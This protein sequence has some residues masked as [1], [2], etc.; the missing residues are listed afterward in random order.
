MVSSPWQK[1]VQEAQLPFETAQRLCGLEIKRILVSQTDNVWE[2]YFTNCFSVSPSDQSIVEELLHS[3]FGQE[4]KLRLFFEEREEGPKL[5]ELLQGIEQ[6]DVDL[7]SIEQEDELYNERFQ[8][9]LKKSE[10]SCP[11]ETGPK[12]V[13]GRKIT[14]KPRSLVEIADESPN[15][16]IHGCVT[17]IRDT[18]RL[19]TGTMLFDFDITDYTNSIKVKLFI[20]VE[21]NRKFDIN[22]LC[23][24]NWYLIK[25]NVKFDQYSQELTMFPTD[26]MTSKA[27]KRTDQAAEKR[28]ELHLHTKLSAMDAMNTPA[29]LIKQAIAWGH[30]AIAIT[31]HGVVQAFPDA[32]K[33]AKV[34]KDGTPPPIKIIYGLEGYLIDGDGSL[35]MEQMRSKRGRS[36]AAAT[37]EEGVADDL[38]KEER[39]GSW[40][41]IL[42]AKNMTGIRNLYKLVSLSHLDFF[43][44]KPR[45]PRQYIEKYREGLI[46]GSACEA[47]ELYQQILN[48]AGPDVIGKTVEFYDYLEIQPIMNNGFMI[49][50]GTVADEEALRK[51]NRTILQLGRQYGK[52]VVATGDV[53][54]LNPEDEVYRRI[55][56]AGQHYR[57]ADIQPPLYFRTTEE[58]LQEFSYLGQEDAYEVVVKAPRAIASQVEYLNPIPNQLQ[59]PKIEGAEEQIKTMAE[60]KAL[61]LYG[62][63]LPEPVAKRLEKELYSI[64][65][66]GYAVLY[67]IAHKLVKHSNEDG[68]VVGSRGS[69]GSS[70]VAFL[71]DITEVNPLEPHYLCSH[72]HYI[73][74]GDQSVFG[75]GADMP[76]KT[77]PVC[78]QELYKD[79]F[80]IPF[81][82][83]LGFDGDKVPDIDLNFSGEYQ[84]QAQK[85]TEELFGA[86]NVF[87]AG[88]IS[89]VAE[90]TAYGFVKNYFLDRK[91]PAREAE[92][93]RLVQGVAGVKKTTGQ[94][95]GGI[96]VLPKG[97]E[98]TNYTPVQHP[99]DDVNSDFVTTH[100]D[101]HAIDSCLVKLDI[102]GHDDPTI[103]R[104]LEDMTGIS[105]RDIP[106]DE[107]KVLSLFQG[108]EALGLSKEETGIE[109]GSIGLPEFGTSFV[110]GM[111]LDTKPTTFSD[112]VRI[113]GF[114]HG[115]DV[116]LG[117]AKDILKSQQATMKEVIAAR[118]DIMI[119]LIQK[120]V[121]PKHAFKIMEQVRKGKGLKQE[122]ITA[123]EEAGVPDWYIHSCQKIKYMFPKAHAV[124]YVT[125]AFRIAWFKVYKPLAYYAATFSVRGGSLEGNLAAGGLHCIERT[126]EEIRYRHENKESTAKDE[127]LYT[128]LELAREMLLRGYQFLPVSLTKSHENRFQIAED[129]RSLRLPFTSLPGLGLSVAQG[130]VSAR[131]EKPFMS[132]ED[133]RK[134][135]RAGKSI[136]EVLRLHGSLAGLPESDQQTLF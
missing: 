24:K 126:M 31:D 73:E 59:T 10:G 114:S 102:L 56:M 41:I 112:L 51:I 107:P 7:P 50:E 16:V 89:T 64:T 120:G 109:T 130:I 79:G 34:S 95:P 116:W 96:V 136:I 67:L 123:M 52:P 57:D 54:F 33:I 78:G 38:A 13:L 115:T 99:A 86:Q 101:Y 2:F 88:T 80:N 84:T 47:G 75:C 74:F 9:M 117:N 133:L 77:C 55:L 110:R 98:I 128:V 37:S 87:K 4:I 122:D 45:I 104:L 40:H 58:M 60:Q 44:K 113:S 129:G 23:E 39:Q 83:F 135:G 53:H 12:L 5:D 1:C 17:K 90:K 105:V 134:R 94:H 42:L 62:Q 72:C 27:Q 76:N 70:F 81:E 118:D 85:Y 8:E 63:P 11:N 127:D 124:A 68:Y 82:V 48:Q 93:E 3:M 46:I 111:L 66:H 132:I 21:K 15:C 71:T 121:A 18:R 92:I 108:P 19:K 61:A 20:D 69:V 49:R 36:K 28:V 22:W 91:L 65:K 32:M 103:I 35:Y 6:A 125:M 106:L 131:N 100:F 29:E 25:G 30:E 43:Y 119:Y 97:D 26:I 14:G